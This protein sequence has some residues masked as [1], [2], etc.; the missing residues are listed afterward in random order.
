MAAVLMNIF[1]ISKFKCV[2]V[3]SWDITIRPLRVKLNQYRKEMELN[4]HHYFSI[5][6]NQD[7]RAQASTLCHNTPFGAIK[8]MQN[9]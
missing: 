3:T 9:Y 4:I 8:N 5:I 1:S 6:Q 7:T 2:S